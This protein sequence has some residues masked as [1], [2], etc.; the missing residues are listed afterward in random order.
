MRF[1]LLVCTAL[2]LSLAACQS[3][4]K[5]SDAVE[6]KARKDMSGDPSFQSFL[7]RLRI[8]VN[9]R[10]RTMMASLMTPDFGFRWD[11]GAPGETPFDYWEQRN[12]W[13]ELGNVLR[14]KFAPND[15]YMVAP[16]QVAEDPSF[17]GYRAGMRQIRG[18]WR[19]AYFVPA[20][21]PG[22]PPAAAASPS[23][24]P[25]SLQPEALPGQAR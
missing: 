25:T 8:A 23:F 1:C 9:K 14:Q 12:L 4:Y 16:P 19:F 2:L 18:S 21:P 5:K 3:P 24:P 10:D 17:A 15:N 7:G 20:P 11:N 22:V 6:K 13:P